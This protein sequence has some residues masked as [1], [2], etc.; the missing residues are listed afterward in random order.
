[1]HISASGKAIIEAERFPR[2]GETVLDGSS[3]KVGTVFDVF[4]P[5]IAPYVAVQMKVND[6]YSFVNNFLYLSSSIRRRK[7]V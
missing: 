2:V 1:M 6:P 4:G 5:T 7:K 3:K